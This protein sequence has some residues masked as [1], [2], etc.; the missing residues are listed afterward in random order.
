MKSELSTIIVFVIIISILSI[1]FASIAPSNLT[2]SLSITITSLGI[3]AI[4]YMTLIDNE[5][6]EL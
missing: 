4:A 2:L 3:I 1:I 6:K 5:D